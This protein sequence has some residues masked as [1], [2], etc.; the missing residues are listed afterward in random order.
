MYTFC[1]QIILIPINAFCYLLRSTQWEYNSW[2]WK[3]YIL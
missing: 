2:F 3:W 1:Y